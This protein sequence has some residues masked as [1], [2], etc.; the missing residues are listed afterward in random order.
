VLGVVFALLLSIGVAASATAAGEATPRSAIVLTAR[1]G[2]PDPNFERSIVLVTNNV[3]SGP[4]GIILNRPTRATLGQLFPDI[5]NMPLRDERVYFGGPVEIGVLS[6]LVRS[7]TPPEHAVKIV[8]DVYLSRDSELLRTLLERGAT[9]DTIRVFI[10]Y[11]G[12]EPDQLE[13]EMA[14]GDWKGA[15][16]SADTI[17]APKPEHPWPAPAAPDTQR[18]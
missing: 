17:F 5:A 1:A 10:G 18:I 16:A 11:A 4:F 13:N 6:F 3:A 7:P 9:R 12:W 8:A 14:R 15:P 2:L